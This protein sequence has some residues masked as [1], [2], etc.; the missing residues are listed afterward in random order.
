MYSEDIVQYGSNGSELISVP[1]V[2]ELQSN[3]S[4]SVRAMCQL[5]LL[6]CASVAGKCSGS[7]HISLNQSH[8]SWAGL[9]RDATAEK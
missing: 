1:I 9:K 5:C 4:E 2:L 6:L 7:F 3:H 8:L